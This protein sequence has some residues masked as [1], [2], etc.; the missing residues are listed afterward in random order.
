MSYHILHQFDEQL[1]ADISRGTSEADG[2]VT[3][4]DLKALRKQEDQS[5]CFSISRNGMWLV[6][7]ASLLITASALLLALDARHRAEDLQQRLTALEKS[8]RRQ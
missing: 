6:L 4:E 1:L 3:A 2:A 5:S 7:A 8:S